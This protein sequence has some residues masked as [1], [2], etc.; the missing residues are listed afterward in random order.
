[1]DEETQADYLVRTFLLA[2]TSRSIE[3]VFWYDFQNDGEDPGEAEFNFGIVRKDGT[4]KPAF[5]ALKTL[6]SLV[7]DLGVTEF[8]RAGDACVLRFDD[9]E[10]RL[11][12]VWRSGGTDTIK[13]ACPRGLYRL[14]ERDGGSRMVEAKEPFL[15]ISASE[16]P[17]YLVPADRGSGQGV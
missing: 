15:E 12:A 4:P 10:S 11:T 5:A 7:K 3:R 9:G 6:T 1:M 16:S 13:I 17:R 8:R 14:V 2:R